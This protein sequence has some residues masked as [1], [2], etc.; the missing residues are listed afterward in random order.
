MGRVK[1][2][3][4]IPADD[5]YQYLLSK[6]VS[7]VHAKGMLANMNTE[8]AGFNATAVGDNGTSVGLAQWH[9][10]RKDA[11]MNYIKGDLTNWK[12]QLDYGLTEAITKK[13]LKQDF[14][15][16]QEASYWFTT[17]WEIPS[18]AHNKALERQKYLDNYSPS[19]VTSPIYNGAQTPSEV[20]T[21]Q[22]Y[23]NPFDYS[24][25]GNN[26]QS[27]TKE[28]IEQELEKER[29]KNEELLQTEAA[30]KLEADITLKSN[31]LS[32]L[33]TGIDSQF[34][35]LEGSKATQQFVQQPVAPVQFA[36]IQQELP[37]LREGGVSDGVYVYDGRPQATYKKIDGKWY[38]SP[39]KGEDFRLIEKGNVNARI[40][41]LEKN[42]TPI[43]IKRVIDAHKALHQ[44]NANIE[45]IQLSN[46]TVI[47]DMLNIPQSATTAY[48]TDNKYTKPSDY[49][50]GEGITDNKVIGVA[51]DML[52]DPMNI[53]LVKNI[54]P[55][56]KV[57]QTTKRWDAYN[58]IAEP[59]SKFDLMNK[60]I[61]TK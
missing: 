29:I 36:P 5:I 8:S 48:L 41:E 54:S 12:G 18:D 37:Q 59:L 7:D 57:T 16:P 50:Q 25:P 13:Y 6:G 19:G 44:S 35:P 34:V 31:L 21:R 22:G 2:Q 60:P 17:K 52:L 40:S 10:P 23:V 56:S 3:N 30:K 28:Q 47:S 39:T 11:L 42:A 51:A 45:P 43:E 9:G 4:K 24:T 27:I 1:N 26:P 61:T 38:I 53:L 20:P 55:Y 49:L 58:N 15:T 33:T 14:K 32:N 46:N